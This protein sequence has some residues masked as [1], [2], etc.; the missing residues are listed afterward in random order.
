MESIGT[1]A[2]S[3][4]GPA[5]TIALLRQAGEACLQQSAR[6]RDEIDLVLHT[7][8]YRSDFLCEPALAAIAAG[9]LG[10]TTT[11]PVTAPSIRWPSTS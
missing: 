10:S 3:E 9:V 7:G 11:K 4:E 5:D 1:V 6:P 8:V 2:A